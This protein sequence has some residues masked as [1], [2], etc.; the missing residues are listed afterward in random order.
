MRSDVTRQGMATRRMCGHPYIVTSSVSA[1]CRCC[2]IGGLHQNRTVCTFEHMNKA[3][4]T[5]PL[6]DNFWRYFIKRHNT[7]LCVWLL[8][9]YA[10]Y[11][12]ATI[13]LP[14][15][16][17]STISG[18]MLIS[19]CLIISLYTGYF[20]SY[21]GGIKYSLYCCFLRLTYCLHSLPLYI[22]FLYRRVKLIDLHIHL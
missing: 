21:N 13:S 2:C 8:V 14:F 4:L 17:T 6:L 11:D 22:H 7:Y 20:L 12:S 5:E 9:R 10:Y 3:G 15:S 1:R 19:I 18:H 16:Q